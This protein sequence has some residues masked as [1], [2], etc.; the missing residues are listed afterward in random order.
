VKQE[1]GKEVFL[2]LFV[3]IHIM[4]FT[5]TYIT[6]EIGGLLNSLFAYLFYIHALAFKA[7]YYG[8]KSFLPARAEKFG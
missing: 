7:H 3:Q 4:A 2:K 1:R 8:V 6:A 5:L